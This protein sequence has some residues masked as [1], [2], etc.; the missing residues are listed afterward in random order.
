MFRDVASSSALII[1][2]EQINFN[3]CSLCI[4]AYIGP[5][6]YVLYKTPKPS[7]LPAQVRSRCQLALIEIRMW[8]HNSHII[9]SGYD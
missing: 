9:I 6:S 8:P 3:L 2:Q 7:N 5:S 4:G 1:Y